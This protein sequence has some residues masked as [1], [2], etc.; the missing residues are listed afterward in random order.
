MVGVCPKGSMAHPDTGLI[1]AGNVTLYIIYFYYMPSPVS[2][3]DKPKSH[4]VIGYPIGQA[5]AILLARD[6]GFV[7]HN[8]SFIDH[9]YSVNMAGYCKKRNLA[10]I[11]PS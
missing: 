10:N 6:T 1:P 4:A 11:Q 3:Q 2:R 5:G 8:K 9:A 7:Q